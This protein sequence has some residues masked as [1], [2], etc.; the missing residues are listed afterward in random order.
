VE[1]NEEAVDVQAA[2]QEMSWVVQTPATIGKFFASVQGKQN[3]TFYDS[4]GKKYQV[5]H[6]HFGETG[7]D[8]LLRTSEDERQKI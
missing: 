3:H 6:R 7:E 1:Q 2:E 5:H 8:Q 4:Q